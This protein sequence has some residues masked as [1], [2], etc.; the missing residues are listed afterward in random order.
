MDKYKGLAILDVIEDT[1]DDYVLLYN[2]EW[3]V[4]GDNPDEGD[5]NTTKEAREQARTL[6]NNVYNHLR[7]FESEIMKDDE[8]IKYPVITHEYRIKTAANFCREYHKQR[9]V[10]KL[11]GNDYV[12]GEVFEIPAERREDF[13][14][15]FGNNEKIA[16]E[17]LRQLKEVKDKS[18][19]LTALTVVGTYK[20]ILQK[21]RIKYQKP[22]VNCFHDVI[23][24]LKLFKG[25]RSTLNPLF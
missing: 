5:C 4:I 15:A 12:M 6:L 20:E 17:F 19:N 9:A 18:G 13:L 8:N 21:Y 23:I 14:F 11:S 7:P 3:V 10:T 22:N 16:Q 2:G 1:W 25:G 24:S